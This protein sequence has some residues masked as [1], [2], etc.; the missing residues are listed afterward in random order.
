[1]RGYTSPL[2]FCSSSQLEIYL[3]ELLVSVLCGSQNAFLVCAY[4]LLGPG[5][6]RE[7]NRMEVRRR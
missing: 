6:W 4:L 5:D 3:C 1:M 2:F 7:C